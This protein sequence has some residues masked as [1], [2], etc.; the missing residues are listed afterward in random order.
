MGFDRFKLYELCVQDPP[1]LVPLLLALHGGSPRILGE[2]FCGTAALSR[3]W[4]R[5]VE[6]G[7]AIAVDRD[8]Q[9]LRRIPK[10]PAVTVVAGDV[11]D[12]TR[13]PARFRVDIL[14]AGNF[15]ICQWHTRKDL[16]G[17]LRHARARLR[18]RGVF[19]CDLY[20]GERAFAPGS[21]RRQ[22][23]LADGRRVT[24]TWEQRS[25]DP[26]TGRVLNAIHFEVGHRG[27]GRRTAFRDAFVYDWRL[28]GV[29]EL[30]DA[31]AE[32]GFADSD[33]YARTP[34]AIDGEGQVHTRPLSGATDLDDDYDVLVAARSRSSKRPSIAAA[35]TRG[36]RK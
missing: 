12:A 22:H 21:A 28:W 34:E 6:G 8:P 33:V 30:R 32:A 3:E 27:E 5:R 31:L 36:S 20:G 19:V 15:S 2:D 13:P 18:P 23:R 16:L 7:R 1:A 35:I 29:P 17:Y 14:H 25:A 9:A 11:V 26:L 10:H 4:V 24:Y